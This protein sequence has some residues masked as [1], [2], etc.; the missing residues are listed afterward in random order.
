MPGYRKPR[1]YRRRRAT[2]RR[3]Q[4]QTVGRKRS[5]DVREAINTGVG[6]A[7]MAS[8]VYRAYN[9]YRGNSRASS[10][11]KHQLVP[12]TNTDHKRIKSRLGRRLRL[13]TRNYRLMRD[14]V[15]RRS[16]GLTNYGAWNRGF[17]NVK[18]QSGQA[19]AIG[20]EIQCPVHLYDL[21]AVPQAQS[22]TTIYPNVHYKLYFTDETDGCLVNWKKEDSLEVY[23]PVGG[24][25]NPTATVL[26]KESHLFP[27]F[28]DRNL[29][30]A[31]AT[32]GNFTAHVGP[33]S[34]LESV[35]CRLGLYGPQQAPTKWLIQ[36]VQLHQDVAPHQG[37]TLATAFWQALAKPYGYSPLE[38]GNWKLV[39]KKLKVLKSI[40]ITMDAPESSEDHVNARMRQVDFQVYLNRR[41]NYRWH[42]NADLTTMN[43]GDQPEE[44]DLDNQYI[45][46]H[47]HPNARVYLMVRAL[48]SYQG[49]GAVFTNNNQASMDLRLHATHRSMD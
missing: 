24:V 36:V 15:L 47:V 18:I 41:C 9:R 40:V 33:K 35:N 37:S 32:A 45:K 4:A 42:D 14:T 2:R 34:F 13:A 25:V 17:G 49:P 5:L 6:A 19:G 23:S 27:V 12:Q 16:L 43:A 44:V 26:R 20:S 29:T 30:D 10:S 8:N 31:G 38:I 21:T 3:L 22:N 28:Y 1:R 7:K 11:S 46:T 48:T 39:K